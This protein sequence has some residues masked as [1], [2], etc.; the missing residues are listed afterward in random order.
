MY[1]S[2]PCQ[3]LVRC[4]HSRR[5]GDGMQSAVVHQSCGSQSASSRTS[6]VLLSFGGPVIWREGQQQVVI[7][8]FLPCA[9]V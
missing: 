5:D 3:C 9:V 2:A 4:P 6:E 7:C 1:G 8:G